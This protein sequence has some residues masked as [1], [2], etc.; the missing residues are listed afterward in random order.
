LA[1]LSANNKQKIEGGM[2]K[3]WQRLKELPGLF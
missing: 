2:N 3:A 1:T